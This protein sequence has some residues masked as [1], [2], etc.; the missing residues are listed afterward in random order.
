MNKNIKC[1]VC[2]AALPWAMAQAAANQPWPVCAQVSCRMVVARR[3]AMGDALFKPYVERQA[4]LIRDQ[5]AKN[6][7]LRQRE[8]QESAE[9]RLGF[10]TLQAALS[11]AQAD[12]TQQRVVLPSGPHQQVKLSRLRRKRYRLHLSNMIAKALAEPDGGQADFSAASSAAAGEDT[13]AADAALREATRGTDATDASAAPAVAATP[14]HLPGHLCAACGGGCCTLG[15]DSAYVSARTIRRFMATMP[16]MQAHEVLASYMNR[17]SA[18]TQA[19]SCI[20]HTD[21]GCSLSRE[22]RSDICNVYAC[23][24]LKAVEQAGASGQAW[25]TILVVRRRLD[26]W[27]RKDVSRDNGIVALL[28]VSEEGVRALPA[29][30]KPSSSRAEPP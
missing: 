23:D 26:N 20:N 15:G 10:D 5:A 8:Q 6:A 14:A 29:Q 13:L 22:M 17:L 21:K 2:E 19:G 4:R 25:Q 9:N 11:P 3:A 28:T 30:G 12:G 27:S 18:R 24:E 7:L 1:A 16:P